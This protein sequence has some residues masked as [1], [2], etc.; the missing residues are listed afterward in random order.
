MTD[1]LA[2]FRRNVTTVAEDYRKASA[3]LMNQLK[4]LTPQELLRLGPDV[5]SKLSIDQYREVVAA[6]APHVKIPPMREE[7]V[8]PDPM[9]NRL[10]RWWRARSPLAQ[11]SCLTALVTTIVMVL[12]IAGWP[13]LSWSLAPFTL[14]RPAEASNWPACERLVWTTDGCVYIPT[15]D[16]N[17]DWIAWHLHMP[18][19]QLLR[20]NGHLPAGYAPAGSQVVVW[21]SR[22]RL[23]SS[24][25]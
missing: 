12:A 2:L 13:A 8:E 3:A 6:V 7:R 24:Q 5:W 23:T 17:W 4:H 11:S 19:A 25:P 18:A 20:I 14:V 9:V 16:L 21:R 10:R 22:G 15:I 1:R